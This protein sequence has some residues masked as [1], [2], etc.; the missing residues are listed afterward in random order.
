[1]KHDSKNLTWEILDHFI[2][3]YTF[4]SCFYM[5]MLENINLY[6]PLPESPKNVYIWT[7]TLR[8]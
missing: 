2:P 6:Q 7:V 5:F 4:A 3:T 1:M 8:I